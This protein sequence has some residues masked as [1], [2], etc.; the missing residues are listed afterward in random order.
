MESEIGKRYGKLTVIEDT[1]KRYHQTKLYKCLCD[2]GN[3][4]EVNTNQLHSGHVT[5]CGCA[6]HKIKDLTGLK[7]G[8]LTVI[9]F[10]ERINHKTLWNCKCDC[11]NTYVASTSGLTMKSTTSCGCRNREN[12]ANIDNLRFGFV[13][14]TLLSSIKEDRKIN[15]NNSS[16]VTGVSWDKSRNMWTAQIMFK[17]EHYQLGRFKN[18]EDAIAARKQAEVDYFG[19]YRKK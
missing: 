13:D 12:K 9:S 7:F 5:S 8:R 6:K 10:K 2:C 4:K 3:Y 16:G 19:K 14:G 1:G 18:K 17:G 11:G 15:K